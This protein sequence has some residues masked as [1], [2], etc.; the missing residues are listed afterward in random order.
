MRSMSGLEQAGQNFIAGG[1]GP[2]CQRG[3]AMSIALLTFDLFGTVLD[4]RRGLREALGTPLSDADFDRIVDRQGELERETF[5]PYAE[6]VAQSLVDE[7]GPDPAAA[8][9]IGSEAGRG[10]LYDDSAGA[11]RLLPK[12]APFPALTHPHPPPPGP[13]PAPPPFPPY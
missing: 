11:P 8:A 5:R 10:P 7:A 12:V 9:R 13:V 4:W 2:P 1:T 6:I 3:R